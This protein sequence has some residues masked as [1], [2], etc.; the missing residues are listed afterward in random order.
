M[1]ASM[2][3]LLALQT[4]TAAPAA[5]PPPPAPPPCT[6]AEYRAMDFWVGE[7]DL[8]FPNPDGS[9]GHAVNRITRDEFGSCVI[10]EHF[11]QAGIGYTG[12]SWSS[13]DRSKRKWVQTWVDNQG[14]YITLAGGP[15]EG[16]DHI[17]RLDTVD[18]RGPAQKHFR[19]IWQKVT[20]ESLTWRWQ[21]RQD[22]GT[23]T[24]SWVID[25]VR[26]K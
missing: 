23:Y 4:A 21:Q 11:E 22:D 17:F 1:S 2:I 24:D 26:R 14:G 13:Y 12:A 16:Q 5:A 7:W 25:Y 3:L 20:P 18:P 15:V 8:N 19:M 9:R 6:S 10:A